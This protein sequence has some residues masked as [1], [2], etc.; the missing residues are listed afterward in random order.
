M[1]DVTRGPESGDFSCPGSVLRAVPTPDEGG[2]LAAGLPASIP[3]FFSRAAAWEIDED[4][5]KAEQLEV[6]LRYAPTRVLLS[7]WIQEPE[8]IA[9]KAAWIR[10]SHGEG[11]VH[12]FGF[13]PQYRS[14]STACFPLLFRALLLGDA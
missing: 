6:L 2:A 3:M 5:D 13:R 14:W 11:K 12:L 7:G 9:D 4:E 8:V 1:D 10:A